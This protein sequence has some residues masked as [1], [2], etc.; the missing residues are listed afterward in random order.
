MNKNFFNSKL[1]FLIAEISANHCGSFNNAKK[2][3]RSAK[4]NGANAVKLQTFTADSMTI[5]SDKEIFK[6]KDGLWKGYSLWDLYDEAKTPLS[7]HEELFRYGKK[8]G[9]TIFSTP[10]DENAVDFL[11]K[12]KCPIYKISSFEMTHL[13]TCENFLVLSL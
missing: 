2:L 7:W 13:Y 8:I 6:I 1:P 5:K 4:K 11:E 10:F 9:I 12:L 3:I